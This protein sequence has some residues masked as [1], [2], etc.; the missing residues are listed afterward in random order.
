MLMLAGEVIGD[1][2]GKSRV[3]TTMERDIVAVDKDGGLIVDSA[4]VEQNSVARP[5]LWHFEISP[6]PRVNGLSGLDAR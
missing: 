6:V 4:K 1:I 3:A 5:F 2:H